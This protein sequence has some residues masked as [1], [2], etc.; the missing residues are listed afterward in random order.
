[1]CKSK[2]GEGFFAGG[3]GCRWVGIAHGGG[4]PGGM[5]L[6]R[7]SLIKSVDAGASAQLST[8]FHGNQRL[9]GLNLK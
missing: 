6:F 9:H 3:A 5:F 1:M 7:Q 2:Q 8:G 4:G